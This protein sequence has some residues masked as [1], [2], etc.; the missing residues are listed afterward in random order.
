MA[1]P[2]I[3]PSVTEVD[4]FPTV[5]EPTIEFIFGETG[6]T[7]PTGP[8][9]PQGAQGIPGIPGVWVGIA[10]PADTSLLWVDTTP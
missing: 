2:I 3:Y 1:D 6:L 4:V 8:V 5:V 7:G 10:P 9:G